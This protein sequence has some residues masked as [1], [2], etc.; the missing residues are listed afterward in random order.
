MRRRCG[1]SPV[2]SR[3][4]L[5]G[6]TMAG[7]RARAAD[8]DRPPGGAVPGRHGGRRLRRRAA[9]PRGRERWAPARQRRR[10]DRTRRAPGPGPRPRVPAGAA[11][12]G[13]RPR[14]A[15]WRRAGVERDGGGARRPLG[16][17]CATHHGAAARVPLVGRAVRDRRRCPRPPVRGRPPR[18]SGGRL[19]LG[20]DREQ[21]GAGPGRAA[22]HRARVEPQAAV[23]AVPR[24]DRSDPEAGGATGPVRPRRP[25]PRRR[26]RRGA[27]WRPR[28]ATSTSPTSTATS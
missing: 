9:R 1:T 18:R 25:P 27:W 23:V 20:A 8:A 26:A 19:R 21:R 16:C 13:R 11:V 15:R 14:R 2:P 24:P 17:R 28:P 4:G 7:F 3:P 10:G 22:R 6:V 12:T 5:P